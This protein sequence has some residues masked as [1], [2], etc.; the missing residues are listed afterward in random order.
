MKKKLFVLMLCVY[1]LMTCCIINVFA[2]SDNSNM[3]IVNEADEAYYKDFPIRIFVEISSN[4]A[5][6][7]N[8][9]YV[10]KESFEGISK[11]RIIVKQNS[12]V[13]FDNSKFYV[14][15]VHYELF[16]DYDFELYLN[17]ENNPS[18]IGVLQFVTDDNV[19]AYCNIY[20]EKVI[21]ENNRAMRYENEPNGVPNDRN[22]IAADIYTYCGTISEYNDTDLWAFYPEEKGKVNILVM[23]SEI[24]DIDIYIYKDGIVQMITSSRQTGTGMEG[25]EFWADHG[26]VYYL[27]ISYKTGA[28]F[29]QT[30]Y[31]IYVNQ[32]KGTWFSQYNNTVG[33]TWNANL[34]N[35]SKFAS[36]VL[37][38]SNNSYDNRIIFSSGSAV[39]TTSHV[40]ASSCGIVSAAMVLNNYCKTYTAYDSRYT[41]PINTSMTADPFSCL[42]AN[43]NSNGTLYSESPR[44]INYSTSNTP[45]SWVRTRLAGNFGMTAVRTEFTSTQTIGTRAMMIAQALETYQG[46]VVIGFKNGSNT[47]F[48]VFYD[49]NEEAGI[50]LNSNSTAAEIG[51]YFYVYDCGTTIASKGDCVLYKNCATY[52]TYPNLNYAQSYTVMY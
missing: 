32:S 39:P 40:M 10:K 19:N 50:T 2:I 13:V 21:S 1:Y 20:F 28:E 16:A 49:V 45:D 47:H 30:M 35:L 8:V 37:D 52:N 23:F 18:Y 29:E 26:S 15:T 3:D 27:R 7:V 44:I 38:E 31:S 41:T 43:G 17:D 33:T 12:M 22:I 14:S 24:S 11:F 5:N 46:G 6:S 42:L 48:V 4:E 36:C 34:L 51:E 25:V 9:R